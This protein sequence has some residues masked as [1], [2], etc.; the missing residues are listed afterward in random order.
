MS[1]LKT[2]DPE[3]ESL[4]WAVMTGTTHLSQG[5]SRE[6]ESEGADGERWD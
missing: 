5:V 6:A 2:L 1:I 3:S 4:S